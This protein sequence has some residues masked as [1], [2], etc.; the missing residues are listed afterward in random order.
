MRNR[1]DEKSARHTL[2]IGEVGEQYTR[3]ILSQSYFESIIVN[4]CGLDVIAFHRKLRRRLGISV[5]SRTRNHRTA[6][7]YVTIFQHAKRDREKLLETC[8]AFSAE[9]YIAVFVETPT[10]QDWYLTSLKHFD[11]LCASSGR[12]AKA[13]W[14]MSP[15][16]RARYEHDPEI[17]WVGGTVQRRIGVEWNV[18]PM[19]EV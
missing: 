5:K 2:A 15:D 19:L 6:N 10:R 17:S 13:V 14:S 12:T 1:G 8:A 3:S 9:P 11:E 16:A 18:E 4:Q 7:G